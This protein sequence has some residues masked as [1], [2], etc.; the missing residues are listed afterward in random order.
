[1]DCVGHPFGG[2]EARIFVTDLGRHDARKGLVRALG[3]QARG[4]RVIVNNAG[5]LE[6]EPV[7]SMD[8]AHWRRIMNVNLEAPVFL[9]RDL[10]PLLG[11]E[12]GSVINVSSA[13]EPARSRARPHIA[14]PN[15]AWRH[16][17]DASR[18]SWPGRPSART[19]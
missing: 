7:A 8:A 14:H 19:R 2:G 13:R 15:S 17:P 5:V 1:M 3:E 12:G 11:E 18:W 16:S 6:R 4:L 10:L 9:T